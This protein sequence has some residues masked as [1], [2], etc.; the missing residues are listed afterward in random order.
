[1]SLFTFF[2]ILSSTMSLRTY[3]ILMSLGT[4]ACWVAWAFILTIDPTTASSSIF[5]F[6]YVSLFLA[7]MGTFSVGGFLV[8]S[9]LIKNEDVVFR[10]VRR[11]FRQSI[12]IACFL[13]GTLILRQKQLLAW[14]NFGLLVV[15]FI[16]LEGVVFSN[17]KYSN[18]DYVK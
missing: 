13:I 1:M 16:L 15:I 14:W 7:I 4:L 8:R 5:L 9:W 6:F 17:R 18:K 10:H 3:L 11:T 12:A 2:A